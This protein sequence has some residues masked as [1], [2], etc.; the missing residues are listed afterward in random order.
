MTGR[1]RYL[2]AVAE[3]FLV[4]YPQEASRMRGIKWHAKPLLDLLQPV[5]ELLKAKGG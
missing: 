5:A 2:P 4:W 3:A 1:G